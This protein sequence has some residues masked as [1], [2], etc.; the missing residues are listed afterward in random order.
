MSGNSHLLLDLLLDHLTKESANVK[1]IA[2]F[3]R[4]FE[5]ATYSWTHIV[6]KYRNILGSEDM[7]DKLA[8]KRMK[9]SKRSMKLYKAEM[10][11]YEFA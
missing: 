2:A 3:R 10:G 11:S 4:F 9:D 8:K 1:H 6:S 5:P 7:K